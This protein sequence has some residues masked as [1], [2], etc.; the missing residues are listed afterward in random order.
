LAG[1]ESDPALARSLEAL[2]VRAYVLGRLGR[3]DEALVALEELKERSKREY[4]SWELQAYAHLGIDDRD[5]LLAILSG[6]PKFGIIGRLL[7]KHDASF[8]S[9]RDDPR[10]KGVLPPRPTVQPAT[11]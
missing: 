7:I 11:P 3:R 10:F 8:D 9:I 4:V 6:A 5:A 1:F 2:S